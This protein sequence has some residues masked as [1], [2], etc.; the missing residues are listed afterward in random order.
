VPH[1]PQIDPLRN[2]GKRAREIGK[3]HDL[4]L[5]HF[6]ISPALDGDGENDK[7]TLAFEFDPEGVNK[8][9]LVVTQAEDGM[10][11]AMAAAQQEEMQK[12]A[13]KAREELSDLESRLKGE[14][15]F[16]D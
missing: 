8:P 7:I 9:K 5:I 1:Q 10:R 2:I 12:R 11:E 14:G 6:G 3:D 13:D 4:R 16:L 15:G